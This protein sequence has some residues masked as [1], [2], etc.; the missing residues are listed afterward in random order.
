MNPR[1]GIALCR[2]FFLTPQQCSVVCAPFWGDAWGL[3]VST[4]WGNSG[5]VIRFDVRTHRP[6]L[7][8]AKRLGLGR[9]GTAPLM[10][11]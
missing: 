1:W 9:V 11:R 7:A 6:N 2:L 5:D 4:F 8:K 10:G 3:T